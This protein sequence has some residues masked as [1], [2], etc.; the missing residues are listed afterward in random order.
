MGIHEAVEVVKD[1][2]LRAAILAAA[3]AMAPSPERLAAASRMDSLQAKAAERD[4]RLERARRL[5]ECELPVP[6]EDIAMIVRNELDDSYR[7]LAAVKELLADRDAGRMSKPYL[8]LVGT[9]GVGKTLAAGYAIASRD[10]VAYVRANDLIAISG[11]RMREDKQRLEVIRRAPIAI[12]DEV[13]TELDAKRWRMASFELVD[14]RQGQRRATI[15]AGNVTAKGFAASLDKRTVS[16]M[17]G[18]TSWV[19]VVADDKR[20]SR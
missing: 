5:R 7:P 10:H 15:F 14:Q 3:D 1:A 12:V 13:G 9:V 6:D 8:V 2:A 19:E 17:H 11:S 16:R 18:R 20:M 4:E